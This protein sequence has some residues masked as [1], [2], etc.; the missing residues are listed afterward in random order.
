M[1][2]GYFDEVDLKYLDNIKER[3]IYFTFAPVNRNF[4][5]DDF[6]DHMKEIM[7]NAYT[8]T[9]KLICD[10]SDKKNYLIQYRILK[11]YVRLGSIVDKVDTV[12]SFKQSNWLEKYINFNTQKRNNA[13]KD[14]EKDFHKLLNNPFCGKIMKNIRNRIKVEFIQK[15]DT[16][17]IINNQ[18]YRSM[19]FISHMKSMIVIHS[20]K[21]KYSWINQFI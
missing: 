14:F 7:P 2:F 13:K 17:K 20:N 5:P 15:E 10:C 4:I 11:F 16:D 12:V 21:M 1:I 9:K 18:N 8:Q 3:T 19:V 6:I